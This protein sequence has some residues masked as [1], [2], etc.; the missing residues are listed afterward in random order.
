MR[1]FA[2]AVEA[3]YRWMCIKWNIYGFYISFWDILMYTILISA[4]AAFIGKLFSSD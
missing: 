1:T 2:E 4:I 3:V